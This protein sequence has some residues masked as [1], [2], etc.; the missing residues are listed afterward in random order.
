MPEEEGLI[1][2]GTT[3]TSSSTG[4]QEGVVQRIWSV[5]F[6][7]SLVCFVGIASSGIMAETL[8][9]VSCDSSLA[10]TREV[11]RDATSELSASSTRALRDVTRD[12]LGRT[13]EPINGIITIFFHSTLVEVETVMSTATS[14][15]IPYPRNSRAYFESLARPLWEQIHVLNKT[16]P[17]AGASIFA[18]G[19]GISVIP[20]FEERSM[21]YLMTRR[22]I[23]RF[24]DGVNST[25]GNCMP[26][27]GLPITPVA[28]SG[29]LPAFT[30]LFA[31]LPANEVR[32]SHLLHLGAG[33]M[34]YV[35]MGKVPDPTKSV[36]EVNVVL[37]VAIGAVQFLLGEFGQQPGA[38]H[39]TQRVYATIASSWVADT[40]KNMSHP[41]WKDYEQTNVITACSHGTAFVSQG[42]G[43]E[44]LLRKDTESDDALIASMSTNIADIG[45]YSK[46]LN[47][48]TFIEAMHNGTNEEFCV[49]SLR[50]AFHRI[51]LD[52]YLTVF[53]DTTSI[54]QGVWQSEAEVAAKIALRQETV[55]SDISKDRNVV[56][57]IV[58]AVGFALILVSVVIS[59]FILRPI[60]AMQQ[61]M[62]LVANME[63]DS[64]AQSNHSTLCELRRMQYDF[65]RMV[66]NLLEFRAYVP[67]SV[68]EG[69]GAEF[70][71][72][73]TIEP[74]TGNVAIVFTDIK[75]STALWKRSAGDMNDAMEI[76]N[77]VMRDCCAEFNG[78]EVK[79]IGDSF[80]VSFSDEFDAAK[81]TLAVQEKF[82]KK[83]WPKGL[84]L[85]K[86]GLVIRIGVHYG[87]T[88]AEEN[89]VTGRVDYRGST[90]NLAS[91]VEAKAKG[92]TI[93]ITSDMFAAIKGKAEALGMVAMSHGSHDIRGLGNGHELFLMVPR[94]LRMRF[95]DAQSD[96]NQHRG[97]HS[98][99]LQPITPR[100]VVS[101]ETASTAL[102]KHGGESGGK[103]QRRT[104]LSM[105]KAQATVAVC[106][107]V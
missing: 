77:E 4:L 13:L 40:L 39:K 33:Q 25:Q 75:G 53:I 17:T 48:A 84:G 83:K 100:T 49:A 24:F 82:A 88:I 3:D 85:P 18:G 30:S 97:D 36:A 103:V 57:A 29:D 69:K 52:W 107:L 71:G 27:S 14:L 66:E 62:S 81:F 61:N 11:M 92:G 72:R 98:Q 44:P 86:S 102:S 58:G 47:T 70:G 12:L 60:L 94:K 34:G 32:F 15:W 54:F 9:E 1:N 41:L 64:I 93:C 7:I 56:K 101:G 51:G 79:T 26:G 22:V 20:S 65:G 37:Y 80:M 42:P 91:R 6:V 19:K 46:V 21:E 31:L 68:L 5:R 28:A 50:N 43:V 99:P 35:L 106:R 87:P 55:E 16:E 38:I 104:D 90:V 96:C 74:P 10:D 73:K 2:D 95:N 59:Y 67:L 63:L 8:S 23:V 45:G 78:Y 76:H 89:P 105:I